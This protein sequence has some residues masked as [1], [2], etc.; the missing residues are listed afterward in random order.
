MVSDRSEETKGD[1][2]KEEVE[3]MV[4]LSEQNDDEMDKEDRDEE[5]AVVVRAKTN[6]KRS[7]SVLDDDVVRIT[8]SYRHNII[9]TVPIFILLVPSS[10]TLNKPDS[11]YDLFC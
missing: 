4:D 2:M 7:K 9:P 8:S 1:E 11:I 5:E 3:K 10:F 6:A